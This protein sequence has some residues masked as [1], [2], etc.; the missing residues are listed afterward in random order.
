[1][2]VETVGNE[3]GLL[4]TDHVTAPTSS[5]DSKTPDMN[6]KNAFFMARSCL[7]LVKKLVLKPISVH[8]IL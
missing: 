3:N 7:R 6:A 5:G 2:T 8:D 1:M 4:S